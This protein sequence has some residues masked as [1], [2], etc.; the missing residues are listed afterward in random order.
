M[1]KLYSFVLLLCFAISTAALGQGT[2]RDDQGPITLPEA[3]GLLAQTP[4]FL[5]MTAK[6][7]TY[8]FGSQ[9]P[10]AGFNGVD[11]YFF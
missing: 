10:G 1:I 11:F 5:A 3:K 7:W 2:T 8:Y 4:E 9:S 6:G